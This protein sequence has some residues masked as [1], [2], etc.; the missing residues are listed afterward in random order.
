MGPEASVKACK[1]L[2][3]S[4]L[5]KAERAALM[6]RQ[7]LQQLFGHARRSHDGHSAGGHRSLASHNSCGPSRQVGNTISSRGDASIDI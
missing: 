6:R 1:E 5:A 3:R 7:R 4:D 2:I